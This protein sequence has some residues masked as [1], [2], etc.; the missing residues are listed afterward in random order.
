[1]FRDT[2]PEEADPDVAQATKLS[3]STRS[4]RRPSCRSA[5]AKPSRSRCSTAYARWPR[6]RSCGASPP[7]GGCPP[8]S[9]TIVVDRG[10]YDALVKKGKSLLPSGL[11]EV[12]GSFAVGE[13]VRCLSPHGKEFARGLV[14]YSARELNQIKGLHSTRIE[15]ILGHKVVDEIIHR[16]DLVLL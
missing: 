12:R 10:A 1:M 16:D 4:P 6:R 15:K 7:R 8:P 9:G 11:K 13:C 2:D 5:S 3:A 14:N